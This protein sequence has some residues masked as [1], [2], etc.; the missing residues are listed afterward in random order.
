MAPADAR[1]PEAAGPGVVL[2]V[3]D[4]PAMRR[5]LVRI[6]RRN[7]YDTTDVPSGRQALD[8]ARNQVFEL[9]VSDVQMPDMDGVELLRAMRDIDP[10]LPILLLSGAPDL[11]SAMKAVEYGAFE[12]VSKP[13]DLEQFLCSVDRAVSLC[14]KRREDHDALREYRSGERLRTERGADS[15]HEVRPGA[16]LRGR[17]RIGHLIGHG[18]M[19]SVYVA[20]RED[21]AQMRVA[22]KVLHGSIASDA[23]QVVRF[24]REA[25]TI[26]SINHPNI[27]RIL[28]FHAHEGEPAFLVMELLEGASLG[29]V[30]KLEGPLGQRRAAFVGSQVLAALGAAHRVKVVHRDLKPENVFLT[31]ISGVDDIVKLLD[32]GIAKALDATFDRKLT[33][34]G[35]VLGTPAY[36]APEQARGG[37]VDVRSDLYSVGCVLYEALTGRAPFQAD[38]YNAL[39]FAIHATE[40][41]PL[42]G[43]RSKIDPGLAEVVTKAMAKE[44]NARFQTADDMIRALKP[45]ATATPSEAVKL[46]S[47]PAIAFA[48]T[49][50]RSSGRICAD[51]ERLPQTPQAEP[52][53]PRTPFPK[54]QRSARARGRRRAAAKRR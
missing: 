6:L 8:A 46:H 48:P 22:V 51:G 35:A 14:R 26:A 38:N 11:R 33:Q 28:D 16:L 21:L 5:V 27:V 10:D 9:V 24:R 32:F 37:A 3:D 52:E 36:M 49:V 7:G 12:Y 4:E 44:P 43:Q 40:P 17:Y 18:G 30:I 23:D 2:V 54:T 15:T 50:P 42:G 41:A 13:V 20:V 29:H 31:S 53:A 34:T 45:W 39:L 47:S 19:G 25:E 1:A